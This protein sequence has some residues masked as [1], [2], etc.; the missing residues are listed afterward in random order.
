MRTPKRGP[1][2]VGIAVDD[3]KLPVYLELLKGAGYAPEDFPM[4]VENVTLLRVEVRHPSDLTELI[5]KAERRC[6][7][8]KGKQ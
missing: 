4:G 5:T 7:A 8:M 6:A 1:I 3:W 2:K